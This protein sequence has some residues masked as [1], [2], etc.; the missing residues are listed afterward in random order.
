MV[1]NS[2]RIEVDHR[3]TP[4]RRYRVIVCGTGGVG[5]AVV[6]EALS[7]PWID[8]VGVQV[9]T[10]AKAGVD[11]G[12]L[13]G[14]PAAGIMTTADPDEIAALDADCVLYC[15]RDF[16][17]WRSNEVLVRLLESGKNVVTPL[18]YFRAESHT[19]EVVERLEEA[20]RRG[21]SSLHA[22]G[23]N[24]GYIGERLGVV[25]TGL[26]HDVSRIKIEEFYDITPLSSELAHLLGIGLPA[27]ESEKASAAAQ[28]AQL[29][30]EQ[31]IGLI[32]DAL[33]VEI[34]GIEHSQAHR[35]A[36]SP[37]QADSYA[38]EEGAVASVTHRW[39]ALVEG[40]PFLLYETTWFVGKS[41]QPEHS[42]IEHHWL[43]T[44][45]GRPSVR[46]LLEVNASM[47]SGA[48]NY[49]G[50]PT[51]AG[52]YAIGIPLV[53]AI[54]RT[55]EAKPGIV[56]PPPVGPHWTA[57][58]GRSGAKPERVDYAESPA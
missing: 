3:P 56:G 28:L 19:P 20:C 1:A 44:I 43:L 50:D 23:L 25:L 14:L 8:V 29:Y 45:E 10:S 12:E 46:M 57:A 40:Q 47:E 51:S 42:D 39:T 30:L 48:A 11:A 53:Q 21:G 54:T 52:N 41:M 5:S 6:R 36:G 32:C 27:S 17:D 26:S 34:D 35:V 49:Q 15:A 31:T 38:V 16:G 37:I 58:R 2:A 4:E 33:G 18:A 7:L 22:T 13:V 9:Y 55:C 24:P